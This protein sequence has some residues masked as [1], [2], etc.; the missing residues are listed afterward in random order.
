MN[1]RHEKMRLLW[2]RINTEDFGGQLT[3]PH[4]SVSRRANTVE[5]AF[6]YARVKGR[7]NQMKL[8]LHKSMF[9]DP[10]KFL[11]A[12]LHEM[13]HQWEV[14]ILGVCA[15]DTDHHGAFAEKAAALSLKYNVDVM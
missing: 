15:Q 9:G 5:G 8:M 6:T 10:D 4:F 13:I 12:M 3:E 1:H 2:N 14:E 11:A 7:A